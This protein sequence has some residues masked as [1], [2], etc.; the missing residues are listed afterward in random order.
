MKAK[1]GHT[2]YSIIV[3]S[4]VQLGAHLI[5]SL[6]LFCKTEQRKSRFNI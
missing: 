5:L 1:G 2:K 4:S 6:L 3:F